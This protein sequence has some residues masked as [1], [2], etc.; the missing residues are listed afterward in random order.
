MCP[1]APFLIEGTADAAAAG[2]KPVTLACAEAVSRLPPADVTLLITSC[3]RACPPADGPGWRLLSPGT[4]IATTALR[5]SDLPDLHSLVLAGGG[6]D[7]APGTVHDAAVGT[8]VGA[9]LLMAFPPAAADHRSATPAGET[10]VIEI[11]GNPAG[12]A[13]ELASRLNPAL[14]VAVL[15]VA[16]GSARHGDAAPGGPD[17]RAD[18]FDAALADALASGD[19]IA[20]RAGTADRELAGDLLATVDPLAV[21]AELSESRAPDAVELL[22]GAAPLGVGYLAASWLWAPT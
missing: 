1:G 4:R 21:L 12:A 13:R 11:A 16:D 5:R 15:V 17:G 6:S 9:H 10:L 8:M 14:R 22:Y 18:A 2:L 3:H 19:P 7:P 20:L